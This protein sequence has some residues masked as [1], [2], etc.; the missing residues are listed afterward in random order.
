[1]GVLYSEGDDSPHEYVCDC[2]R[3]RV[4]TAAIVAQDHKGDYVFTDDELLS[5]ATRKEGVD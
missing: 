2:W 5:L 3:C 4:M 1:M